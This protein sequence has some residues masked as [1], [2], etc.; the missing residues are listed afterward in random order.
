MGKVKKSVV[1][2]EGTYYLKDIKKIA[3]SIEPICEIQILCPI[4][5]ANKFINIP[6]NIIKKSINL[7]KVLIHSG[8]VCKHSLQIFI[9]KNYDVRSIEHFD[10]EL[11]E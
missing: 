9:D 6:Q 8:I 7:A 2:K 3:K 4:C 11:I 1:L 5:H 10:Y